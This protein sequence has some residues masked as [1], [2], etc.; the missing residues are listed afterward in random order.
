[1]SD[2]ARTI[3]IDEAL[4]IIRGETGLRYQGGP[5]AMWAARRYQSQKVRAIL[6]A[7]RKILSR[8]RQVKSF[9]PFASRRINL[10]CAGVDGALD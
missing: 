9:W 2:K 6:V 8:A 5:I 10:E 7:R 3:T 1:M 4:E